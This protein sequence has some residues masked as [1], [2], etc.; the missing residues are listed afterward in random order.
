MVAGHYRD[1][2]VVPS[3]PTDDVLFATAIEGRATYIVSGDLNDV[4]AV[5]AWKPYE[6]AIQVVGAPYFA[7]MVLGLQLPKRK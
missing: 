5:K 6:V 7:R 1:V 3:D 2:R 4:R